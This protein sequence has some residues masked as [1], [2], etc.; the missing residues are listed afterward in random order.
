MIYRQRWSAGR[1]HDMRLSLEQKGCMNAYKSCAC[2][3]QQL[4]RFFKAQGDDKVNPYRIKDIQNLC[5]SLCRLAVATLP[6]LP[7]QVAFCPAAC[8]NRLSAG[9]RMCTAILLAFCS[10]LLTVRSSWQESCSFWSRLCS[11]FCALFAH[12]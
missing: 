7:C 8:Q 5:L 3:R 1:K 9:M 2:M 6:N 4:V 12:T 11:Q 10:T